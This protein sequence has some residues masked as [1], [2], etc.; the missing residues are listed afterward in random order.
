M[1]KFLFNFQR[2]TG[3]YK[4]QNLIVMNALPQPITTQ[5]LR[6]YPITGGETSAMKCLRS[7][8]YGYH[9]G[10]LLFHVFLPMLITAFL[11]PC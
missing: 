9:P 7:E 5:Y 4:F 11:H 8:I 6:I 2:F 10:I 1:K 3:N